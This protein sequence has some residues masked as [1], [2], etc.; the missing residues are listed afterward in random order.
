MVSF[1]FVS[2]FELN[3]ALFINLSREIL[4][5]VIFYFPHKNNPW[6]KEY[7]SM[8]KSAFE[9]GDN[10]TLLGNKIQITL[11]NISATLW[12]FL[13]MY[14]FSCVIDKFERKNDFDRQF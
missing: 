7:Q 6:M 5:N 2:S 13:S 1:S 4:I 8:F 9:N 11:S 14:L 3:T 12:F 10:F